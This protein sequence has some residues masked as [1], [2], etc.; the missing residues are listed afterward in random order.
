[1]TNTKGHV[2]ILQGH[3]LRRKCNVWSAKKH[4]LT[5]KIQQIK[6]FLWKSKTLKQ[7]SFEIHFWPVSQKRPADKYTNACLQPSVKQEHTGTNCI[8]FAFQGSLQHTDCF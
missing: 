3:F 1:M 2:T 8:S 6:P 5:F 7:Y 4:S